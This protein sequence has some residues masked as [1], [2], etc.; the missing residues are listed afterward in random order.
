MK[1]LENKK[2]NWVKP[3]VIGLSVKKETANGKGTGL[4]TPNGG[5]ANFSNGS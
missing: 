3:K 1:N 5:S 2:K 4:E